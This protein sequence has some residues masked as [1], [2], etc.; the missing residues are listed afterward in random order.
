MTC[1]QNAEGDSAQ[2]AERPRCCA[3]RHNESAPEI[4]S[5]RGDDSAAGTAT[6]TRTLAV[7]GMT[8]ASCVGT[9]ERA[10]KSVPEVA[11]AEV[12][13]AEKTARVG[14]RRSIPDE[15]LTAAVSRAGYAAR[16]LDEESE[17]AADSAV[18]ADRRA[19]LWFAASAALTLPLVAQMAFPLFGAAG[20]LPPLVQ[21]LLA[22]PVQVFVGARFYKAAWPAL[23]NLTGNMD[24]LVA[25]G[26]TAAFALSLYNTVTLD[27]GW[28]QWGAGEGL[29][30]E[31]AAAVLTL[32]LLGRILEDRATRRAG[33]AVRALMQLR[34]EV[35]RV[36][37]D[38]EVITVSLT[39][40][41][42]GDIVIVRPGERVPA[43][44]IVVSGETQ[45]DESL[46]TGESLP[47]AKSP[48][49]SVVS[50]AVNGNG[51]I[52]VRTTAVG[53]ESTL[54]R[55]ID[56]VRSAQASKPRIQRLVDQ[57]AAIFV[58]AVV[59]VALG[60][61]VLWGFLG[62]GGEQAVLNA[63]AVLVIACPCALGL[64]TPTAIMVGTG[65]A[66]RRGI[67]IKD[68]T[69]LERAAG[70][71]TVVFDKTGTLTEGRPTVQAV[72]PFAVDR[73]TLLHLAGSAQRGSTHPLAEAIVTAAAEAAGP[74]G[75]PEALENVPGQGIRATLGERRLVIGR[76][77]LLADLGIDLSG[78]DTVAGAARSEGH[79]VVW[80][81]EAE[82]TPRLLGVVTLADR[83]RAGA[84][85]AVSRLKA[86]G[87]TPVML[88][89]DHRQAAEAVARDIGIEQVI[90]DVPPEGKAEAVRDLQSKG[91]VVA[92]VGDGV[93]DAPALAAADVGIAMG[94]G[95]DV[96]LQTAGLALL[97][98]DPV[99]VADAIRLSRAT[100]R[101][102]AQNLGW[103]FGY[104]VIAIPLAAAG[105]LSPMIAGAAMALSSVSVAT[106]SLRLRRTGQRA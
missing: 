56:L 79:A 70:I 62:V 71:D 103:A 12:N 105:L 78:G 5:N 52:R 47:V 73:E 34:P 86:V 50:G 87:V 89:G 44:G 51:L 49:E 7:Q 83:P 65:L 30:Y 4:E 31:A 58:P 55:I 77:E 3:A 95:T 26:T 68:A 40:L 29:Y 76:H 100:R 18:G 46:V 39:A 80:V 13:L 61:A 1:A 74:L 67:L 60:T 19:W 28:L 81:A 42:P 94:G 53:A 45:V 9:V 33:A 2:V 88:S 48:D 97:R 69:A 72:H 101:T 14:L 25:L 85:D 98:N 17:D 23:K 11:S 8:C 93:N 63:V 57:V 32:V 43:D 27:A 99:L 22:L 35:A 66:A 16:V 10:L 96:A 15:R 75:E 37:R 102:I 20:H 21:L 64:A 36:E 59:A 38:G 84:A 90:A 6:A 54:G 104:N 24:T 106:N 92:M 82:P 91:R 41:R